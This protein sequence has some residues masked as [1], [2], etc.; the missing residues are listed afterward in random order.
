VKEPR[1]LYAAVFLRALA[2][3]M[4]GVILGVHLAK[5]QVG[6]ALTGLIIGAGLAGA[7]GA[8]LLA[9][10]AGGRWGR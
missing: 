2:T 9:T 5:L 10:L 6:A 4:M 8:A 3:G 1:T 7:A